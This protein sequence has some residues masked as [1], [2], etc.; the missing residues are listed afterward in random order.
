MIFRSLAGSPEES[1]ASAGRLSVYGESGVYRKVYE[2]GGRVGK[3]INGFE[4]APPGIPSDFP[5]RQG[6][7]LRLAKIC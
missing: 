2:C 5:L 3:R 7:I 4:D 1:A 6:E